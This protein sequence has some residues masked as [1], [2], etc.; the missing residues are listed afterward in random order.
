MNVNSATGALLQRYL[1]QC[2]AW[3]CE[4][5]YDDFA[6]SYDWVSWSVSLGAWSAWRQLALD[7]LRT[8]ATTTGPTLEIGFGSG[9]LLAAIERA[10]PPVIGLE[11][12]AQMQAITAAK[13]AKQQLTPPRVQATALSMPFEDESFAAVVS[14]FPAPYILQEA[15]LHECSRVLQAAGRLI[16]VGLWVTP[17]VAGHRMRLPLL[18]GGP[19]SAQILAIQTRI[20]AAG[21]TGTLS[22]RA[23][24]G[25]EIA[26]LVGEKTAAIPA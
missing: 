20:E 19:A 4:Q 21:F 12:S 10:S 14:T 7:E 13:L 18:Y 16:V 11:L 26:V 8:G 24:A 25:A 22:L 23:A 2:Y 6:W 9:S 3:A 17:R 15:T 5:L 1:R